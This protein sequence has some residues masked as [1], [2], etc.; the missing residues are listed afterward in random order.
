V[1]PVS[2]NRAVGQ[3]G[4]K[5][6]AAHL[7]SAGFEVLAR[8][9]RCARGEIDIVALDG[10]CLVVCEVKTRRSA[11]CG[12]PLEAVTPAKVDRLRRL[13]ATWL[14]AQDRYFRQ[15]RIDVVAVHRP[16]RGPAQV[17]HLRGV[18]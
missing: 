2:V 18:G 6:A 10:D 4:E 11:A 13:A 14:A 16:A 3:Y 8:N 9:W 12:G 15:V 17:E 7:E 5:V 1:V